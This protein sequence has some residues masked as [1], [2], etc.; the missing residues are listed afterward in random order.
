MIID[1][2]ARI[3]AAEQER[4]KE[5]RLEIGFRAFQRSV[6]RTSEVV[7]TAFGPELNILVRGYCYVTSILLL[8]Y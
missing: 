1:E 7:S 4:K 5:K 6:I 3:H 2:K 8:F